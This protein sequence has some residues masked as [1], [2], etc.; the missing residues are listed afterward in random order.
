MVAV[1]V[2]ADDDGAW[3][4]DELL[5][6]RLA[7]GLVAPPRPS[8]RQKRCSV[9]SL[10]TEKACLPSGAA[11]GPRSP[12]SFMRSPTRRKQRARA[13][14]RENRGLAA[15]DLRSSP[16]TL[17]GVSNSTAS[18]ANIRNG[19]LPS[20]AAAPWASTATT[21]WWSAAAASSSAA[22]P[23][24]TSQWSLGA[25]SE[26]AAGAA[27]AVTAGEQRRR[28]RAQPSAAEPICGGAASRDQLGAW[29]RGR[30]MWRKLAREFAN[31]HGV[32]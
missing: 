13:P 25:S 23:A 4:L 31:S 29:V 1:G 22:T 30:S 5:D 27:V 6:E 10:T 16:R 17:A 32:D 26:I 2:G 15:N 19:R 12:R 3:I 24:L 28:H 21:T 18:E 9:R 8:V 14:A 7:D 20:S 11:Q